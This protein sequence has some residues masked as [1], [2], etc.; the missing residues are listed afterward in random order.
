MLEYGISYSI[1]T[2]VFCV[3]YMSAQVAAN[4]WL[5][6][7]TNDSTAL[8]GTQDIQLRDFRLMVY[9]ALAGLQ[10]MCNINE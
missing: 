9:G 5:S 8:N 10:G 1:V 7:W 6:A 2:L 4:L 3:W